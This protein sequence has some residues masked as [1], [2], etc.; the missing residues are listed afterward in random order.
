FSSS[1]WLG[2]ALKPPHRSP[3]K[4][5]SRPSPS[6]STTQGL[7]R[8]PHSPGPRR[9]SSPQPTGLLSTSVRAA[10]SFGS[11]LLPT[12]RYQTTLPSSAPTIKSS[13]PSPSQS[14][15]TGAA[16]PLTLIG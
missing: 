7:T 1:V 8:K 16:S 11:F 3:S 4:R 6:Q 10:S 9:S 2:L 14:A 12:L 5:S 13:R 15:A